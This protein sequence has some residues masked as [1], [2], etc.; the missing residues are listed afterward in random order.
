MSDSAVDTLFAV[1]RRSRNALLRAAARRV[2]GRFQPYNHTLPDRYPWI[3]QFLQDSLGDSQQLQLLSFG[4]SRGLEVF[5]LRN[6]F[7]GAALKGID[8]DP[9]NIA[10]C[11]QRA[12]S[13][14]DVAGNMTF[15][16]GANL[17][18]EPAESYDA[19]LCLAVL[20]HGDLSLPGVER[21]DHLLRFADFEAQV[22]E[23][24]RCLKPGGLLILHTTNFRLRDTRFAAGFEAVLEAQPGQL[25][26]DVKFGPDN[27]LM[28]AERYHEVGF[29]KR[30]GPP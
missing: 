24:A 16:V 9:A 18:R 8:I 15:A 20:C 25:A 12:R 21:F 3:F 19:I 29:R 26:A 11:L 30:P 4:C 17:S 28:R 14:P 13:Q 27:R 1:L 5:S 10:E 23:F 2:P 6:Y 22:G 7:P